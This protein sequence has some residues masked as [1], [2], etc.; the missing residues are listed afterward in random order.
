M[1]H[2]VNPLA[3]FL[4]PM[5]GDKHPDSYPRFRNVFISDE[6]NPEYDD[7]IHVYTRVGG[8]NR[9]VGCGEEELYKHPNFV[10]TFD[11]S[12]DSTFGTYVFSVP[13]DFKNDFELIKSGKA[14][15]VS[16][17]LRVRVYDMF[18]KLKEQ[19]DKLFGLEA[20]HE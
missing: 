18:P 1:I 4:I 11:D 12:F 19:L 14:N 16:E 15:E 3:I 2:G 9:G 6:E 8:G 10:T 5:L 13:D 7:H 20:T 17:V